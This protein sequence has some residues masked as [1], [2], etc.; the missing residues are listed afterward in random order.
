MVWS[1]EELIG[2]Y[3]NPSKSVFPP[4]EG[5]EDNI[6]CYGQVKYLSVD[7]AINLNL[8]CLTKGG[9]EDNIV[10]YGQ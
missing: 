8:A 10:C 9:I 1:S 2:Q 5:L 3:S 7:I 4:K 6:A